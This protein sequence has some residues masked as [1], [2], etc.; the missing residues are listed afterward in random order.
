MWPLRSMRQVLR[1]RKRGRSTRTKQ[2]ASSQPPM[3]TRCGPFFR[4][5]LGT[6]AR[7]G[8]LLALRWDDVTLPEVGAAALTVRRAFVE[9]K[10]KDSRIV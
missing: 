4:I 2:R 5:A 7:R 8:E 1:V 3:P 9:G 6:G 10:G